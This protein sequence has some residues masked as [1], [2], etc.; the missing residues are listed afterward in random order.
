MNPDKEL[1]DKVH[2]SDIYEYIPIPVAVAKI[3][4]R[5][6]D[7]NILLCHYYREKPTDDPVII[8]HY[9]RYDGYSLYRCPPGFAHHVI[10]GE[11]LKET[12][13][14]MA[15]EIAKTWPKY[16]VKKRNKNGSKS[17]S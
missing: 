6:V 13:E 8:L 10:E 17:N 3:L 4:K 9:V 16:A 1:W 5:K 12:L 15:M 11:T 7:D 2:F 14:T